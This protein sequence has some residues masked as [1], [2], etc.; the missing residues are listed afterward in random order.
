[1]DQLVILLALAVMVLSG[2][3]GVALHEALQERGIL[4]ATRHQRPQSHSQ[5]LIWDLVAAAIVI[6]LAAWLL[7]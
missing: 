4:P 3:F 2:V 7:W 1:M 6:A 5:L